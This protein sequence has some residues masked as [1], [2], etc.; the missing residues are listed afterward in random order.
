M[1]YVKHNICI[2]RNRVRA[3]GWC[4]RIATENGMSGL[5]S[6]KK[7]KASRVSG[8][9]KLVP[10]LQYVIVHDQLVGPVVNWPI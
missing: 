3:S 1:D 4:G 2:K 8:D 10:R 6:K 9:G 5:R 7:E